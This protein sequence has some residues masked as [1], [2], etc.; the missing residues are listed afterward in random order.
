M[1]QQQQPATI[2][3][4]RIPPANPRANYTP[5]SSKIMC[6]PSA[7]SSNR[8]GI[9]GPITPMNASNHQYLVANSNTAVR[10][11]KNATMRDTVNQL[12]GVLAELGIGF[13]IPDE[14]SPTYR[15]DMALDVFEMLV[16][17]RLYVDMQCPFHP[18]PPSNKTKITL[19]DRYSYFEL[20]IYYLH[21]PMQQITKSSFKNPMSKVDNL[22]L[23]EILLQFGQFLLKYFSSKSE[24]HEN[25]YL[26]DIK[27]ILKDAYLNRG[28]AEQL[29]EYT[30]ELKD[31]FCDMRQI[32]QID[33]IE[34]EKNIQKL[35]Q[36]HQELKQK[37]EQV[38]L[39]REQLEKEWNELTKRNELQM[40]EFSRKQESVNDEKQKLNELNIVVQDKDIEKKRLTERNQEL[41]DKYY[42]QQH[43]KDLQE[44]LRSNTELK[45]QHEVLQQTLLL[46]QQVQDSATIEYTNLTKKL[47]ES[48]ANY[49]MKLNN[50][51]VKECV[52]QKANV[53]LI[54]ILGETKEN[55]PLKEAKYA[56]GIIRQDLADKLLELRKREQQLQNEAKAN[57]DELK[58]VEQNW[59]KAAKHGQTKQAQKAELSRISEELR[60]NRE[61]TADYQRMTKDKQQKTE[62]NLKEIETIKS[63]VK[64]YSKRYAKLIESYR[65]QSNSLRNQYDEFLN[66]MKEV[67]ASYN[68]DAEDIARLYNQ[69][70]A[71]I[72]EE[73][74]STKVNG[75]SYD[76]LFT[77]QA[78]KF[79]THFTHNGGDVQ[80]EEEE[81]DD[82]GETDQQK[83]NLNK[84]IKH[85]QGR[86]EEYLKLVKDR[87]KQKKELQPLID[88]LKEIY[89]HLDVFKDVKVVDKN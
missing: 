31:V 13:K 35:K 57:S 51:K 52:S 2:R 50:Y 47:H 46:E 49:Q 3:N 86:H 62:K 81:E 72:D 79:F 8:T 67:A 32:E 69:Y 14:P 60:S 71:K 40:S 59:K 89:D 24:H 70:I 53:E 34:Y 16:D 88:S 56:I 26:K 27:S 54:D 29:K 37:K 15:F 77:Y 58:K 42:S 76:D 36:K 75:E 17:P 68:Q 83:R 21:I 5:Q 38:Q 19:H 39:N 44:K 85:H 74:R 82:G 23:F 1:S 45:Q 11:A 7:T 84:L 78:E 12:N 10:T 6:P 87:K 4:P 18:P 73:H 66:D 61:K 63:S 64:Q 33:K 55:D 9:A 80:E 30:Q 25:D 41:S 20:V 28:D 65:S 22:T 48:L 43:N